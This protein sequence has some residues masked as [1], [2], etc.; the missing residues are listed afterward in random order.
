MPKPM[1][2]VLVS[3]AGFTATLAEAIYVVNGPAPRFYIWKFLSGKAHGSAY[4]NIDD[5]CIYYETYGD[6]TPVL[7]LHGGLASIESMSHQIRALANSHFVIA[8]DS[9]G[10]GRSTD[11]SAPLSYSL[12]SYD[13]LRLLDRLQIDRVDVVGWSDGGIIGLDLAIHHPNRIRRLVAISANY[14]VK[15]LL[16]TPIADTEIPR[17][18]LRYKLLARDPARWPALYRKVITMW[19]TQPHYA[20]TDLENVKVPTL[21]MA[22]EFDI[23]KH[24]HINQLCKAISGSQKTII[25]GATHRLLV[26]KPDIVNSHILRFLDEEIPY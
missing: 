15:G 2:R 18:P 1:A 8:A 21:I 22:G 26:E 6:G 16:Q 4:V 23:I 25:E 14:D 13:M 12:M 9:R 7:V 17:V 19:Q 5:V 24:E 10:H 3:V 20:L 11:S